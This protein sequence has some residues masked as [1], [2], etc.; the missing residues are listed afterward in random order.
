MNIKPIMRRPIFPR[1]NSEEHLNKVFL[2]ILLEGGTA[3]TSHLIN[4]I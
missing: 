1:K 4:F 3:L 2:V